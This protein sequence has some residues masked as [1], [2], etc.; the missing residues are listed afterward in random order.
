MERGPQEPNLLTAAQKAELRR[1][2]AED[3]DR[4]RPPR[5]AN[6]F[7]L[8]VNAVQVRKRSRGAG[9]GIEG[10]AQVRPSLGQARVS[11]ATASFIEWYLV[12]L[13]LF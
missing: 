7:G 12:F 4:W 2:A 6:A 10:R 11:T 9:Q 8:S 13:A 1:L 3:P 5:L